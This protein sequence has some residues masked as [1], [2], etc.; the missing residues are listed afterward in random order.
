MQMIIVFVLMMIYQHVVLILTTKANVPHAKKL[1]N[2]IPNVVTV[3]VKKKNVA[4]EHQQQEY[5]REVQKSREC[6]KRMQ[7]ELDELRDKEKQVQIMNELEKLRANDAKVRKTEFKRNLVK[8]L[9]KM[10]NIV[11]FFY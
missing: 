3:Y 7:D 2:L 8:P 1:Q 11:L 6:M 9:H 5:A 10:L 4:M